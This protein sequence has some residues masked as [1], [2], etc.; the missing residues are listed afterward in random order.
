MNTKST[1]GAHSTDSTSS[2]N[3]NKFVFSSQLNAEFLESSYSSNL[4][5]GKKMFS[6]FLSSIDSDI[7]FL[8][9]ALEADDYT[10]LANVAHKIKNNFTW[11]GLPRMSSLLYKLESAAKEKSA[12]VAVHFNEFM[13]VYHNEHSLVQSEYERMS[14]FLA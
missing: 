8:R 7:D 5:F 2:T 13:E 4:E 1:S 11:V 3:S 10:A 12:E 14:E 6:I 9:G